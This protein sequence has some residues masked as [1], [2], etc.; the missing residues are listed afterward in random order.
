LVVAPV[1]LLQN[2][3]E[4][5]EKFFNPGSFRNPHAV[6]TAV[7]NKACPPPRQ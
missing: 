4:E 7:D 6:R 1:S 2:W 3:K 5:I